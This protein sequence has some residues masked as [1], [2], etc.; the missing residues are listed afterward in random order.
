MAGHEARGRSGRSELRFARGGKPRRRPKSKEAAASPGLILSA[1][2]TVFRFFGRSLKYIVTGI[3]AATAVVAVSA[4]LVVGYLYVSNSDYFAVKTITISGLSQVPRDE[5]LAVAG[6]RPDQQINILTFD[7]EEAESSLKALPWIAEARVTRRMP[8]TVSIEVTEHTP[9][10]LVSL[11]R[12]YY[13]N[14]DGVPFKELTPG[15]KPDMP[16]VT[17]FVEDELLNPGPAVKKGVAEVFWLVETLSKRN[18]EFQLA[19]V[20]EINYDAVRG[21]SIF[22][23]FRY[24]DN[25]GNDRTSV[26]EVKIGFGS[27][28]EKFR[29]LDRVMAHLKAENQ[30]KG[31]TYFNLEVSPEVAVRYG[32]DRPATAVSQGVALEPEMQLRPVRLAL[33]RFSSD[34]V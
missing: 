13:L 28:E 14:E 22:S 32:D 21:L 1:G 25:K 31:L 10:L 5:V 3:L 16:V 33:A 9:K 11:G 17:G 23:H 18:N 29:R 8:D 27:Y 34:N 2:R 15:E 6:L 7:L 12:L 24:T 26:L 4:L 19:N 20:S 30:D